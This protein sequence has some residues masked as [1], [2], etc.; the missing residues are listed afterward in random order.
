MCI[1]CSY[2]ERTHN[3]YNYCPFCGVRL[4]NRSGFIPIGK[5]VRPVTPFVY[6]TYDGKPKFIRED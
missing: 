6:R 2:Y 4:K 3:E 1:K 5:E